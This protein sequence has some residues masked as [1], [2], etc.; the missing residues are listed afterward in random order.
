MLHFIKF[1]KLFE[2]ELHFKYGEIFYSI[3]VI[4]QASRYVNVHIVHSCI[5]LSGWIKHGIK[6]IMCNIIVY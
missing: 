5:A 2:I 3:V 1:A 6:C 4:L